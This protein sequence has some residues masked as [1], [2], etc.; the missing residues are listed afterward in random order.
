[1]PHF[2]LTFS[3]LFTEEHNMEFSLSIQLSTMHRPFTWSSTNI[4]SLV[5]IGG[6]TNGNRLLDNPKTR[7]FPKINI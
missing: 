2:G 3:Q 4:H 5:L 1:M 7:I 6:S